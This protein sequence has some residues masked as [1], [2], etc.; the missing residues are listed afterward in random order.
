[1]DLGDRGSMFYMKIRAKD[2]IKESR[3]TWRCSDAALKRKI[4][5]ITIFFRSTI[6]IKG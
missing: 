6:Y 1:M 5:I 3:N 4:I 2:N